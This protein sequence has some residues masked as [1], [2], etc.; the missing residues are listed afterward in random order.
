MDDSRRLRLLAEGEIRTYSL[1]MGDLL[2]AA[3]DTMGRN[4]TYQDW[5]ALFSAESYGRIFSE[6][7]ADISYVDEL[8]ARSK[9]FQQGGD[10]ASAEAAISEATRQVILNP[11]VDAARSVVISGLEQGYAG[12]ILPAA[13][14]N[15]FLLPYSVE[16]RD[17]RVRARA[18]AGKYEEA[19]DD[20]KYVV[21]NS[22]DPEIR[23]A[24]ST[25]VSLL[26][27]QQEIPV[28]QLMSGH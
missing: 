21:E 2:E 24:R 18:A 27:N 15:V 1:P 25:W 19:I 9:R 17:L 10:G 20:F 22:L 11:A 14:H 8:I 3:A 23:T 4:L 7:P 5:A 6:F 12:A 26:L 28:A 13:D 16:M